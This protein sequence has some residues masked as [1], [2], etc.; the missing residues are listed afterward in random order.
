MMHPKPYISDDVFDAIMYYQ[1]YKHVRA[2]FSKPN[3]YID[4]QKL[5]EELG[6]IIAGIPDANIKAMMT[7][8]ASHD[9][10]RLLSSFNNKNIYKYFAKPLD[11]VNYKT[12]K[13]SEEVYEKFKFFLV[14]QFKMP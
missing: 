2:F 7:M 5:K 3:E 1:P 4:G 8:S 14:Y 13:H 9:T 12:G 6:T 11:N 10:S